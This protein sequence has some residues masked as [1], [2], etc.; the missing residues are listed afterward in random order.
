[1]ASLSGDEE[2]EVSRMLMAM[3]CEAEFNLEAAARCLGHAKYRV[4]LV[5]QGLVELAG[6]LEQRASASAQ[7]AVRGPVD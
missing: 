6:Y 4:G 1:M 5:E 3:V 2:S 7:P